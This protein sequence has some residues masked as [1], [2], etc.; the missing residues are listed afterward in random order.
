MSDRTTE[1]ATLKDAENWTVPLSE[2]EWAR[3]ISLR[4]PVQV[5]LLKQLLEKFRD[6]NLKGAKQVSWKALLDMGKLH[7]NAVESILQE[8]VL[9]RLLSKRPV[10]EGILRSCRFAR[11]LAT[12]NVGKIKISNESTP[13]VIEPNGDATSGGPLQSN[14][15]HPYDR[16][17]LAVTMDREKINYTYQEDGANLAIHPFSLNLSIRA[18]SG[19]QESL[20]DMC[21]LGSSALI[22]WMDIYAYFFCIVAIVTEDMDRKDY[23]RLQVESLLNLLYDFV[24]RPAGQGS[25]KILLE[26]IRDFRV[27]FYQKKKA[28]QAFF[29]LCDALTGMK[30]ALGA[31]FYKRQ[32]QFE[33]SSVTI[34]TLKVGINFKVTKVDLQT[35]LQEQ[36]RE[37]KNQVEEL[38]EQQQGHEGHDGHE[39]TMKRQD[40]H[41]K[42]VKELVDGLSDA[43]ATMEIAQEDNEQLQ[44]RIER[45]DCSISKLVAAAKHHQS[46]LLTKDK[47][48]ATLTAQLKEQHE[49]VISQR[50]TIKRREERISSLTK[51]GRAHE[52]GAGH[53]PHGGAE[54][55][56]LQPVAECKE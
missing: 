3:L 17:Y 55:F 35:R 8:P 36:V 56:A 39:V 48:I 20:P 53:C 40:E 34:S 54:V 50:G 24:S 16:D 2:D 12:I 9:K 30:T 47:T 10:L 31:Q 7:L 19:F 45:R 18:H 44:A 14:R 15:S 29:T 4:K 6:T 49:I 21:S 52:D 43:L 37:L 11:N 13:V 5:R 51:E 42:E 25:Q 26:H 28:A 22:Q 1:S 23:V 33:Y 41:Q 27:T 32:L 38:K 46:A